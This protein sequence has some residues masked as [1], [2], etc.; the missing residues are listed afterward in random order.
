MVERSPLRRRSRSPRNP[1]PDRH[2]N[3]NH[4]TPAR[5][6]HDVTYVRQHAH[7][8]HMH[9][10]RHESCDQFD[11]DDRPL[12]YHKEANYRRRT[13]TRSP[14]R[15]SPRRSSRRSPPRKSSPRRKSP[16]RRERSPTRHHREHTPVRKKPSTHHIRI[17]TSPPPFSP[18]HNT[19]T[20][21]PASTRCPSCVK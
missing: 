5:S 13:R 21:I 19:S 14:R 4:S 1:Y 8:E 10:P 11:S 7:D 17:R 3:S 2:R 9:M 16:A 20:A 15:S 12:P 18:P 6:S